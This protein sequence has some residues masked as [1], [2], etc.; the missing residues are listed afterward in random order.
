MARS[1]NNKIKLITLLS[2]LV[3]C[4]V[5]GMEA[6]R[7]NLAMEWQKYQNKYKTT[8]LRIASS[9]AEKRLARAYPIKMRQIFLPG[10][11]RTDR[12]V[13][14][15]VG[16][17]DPRM[18][19]MEQPLRSHPGK[20]L[21]N[22]D[23]EKFGCTIC[24]DGQGQAVTTDE[25]HA[26]GSRFFW[27]KPLLPAEFTRS[28]CLRCHDADEQ[29]KTSWVLKGKALF[30]QNGCLGCHKLG[31]R[32][33]RIGL[34]LSRLGD[35]SFHLKRPVGK[36]EEVYLNRF[37][38]NKNIAYIFESIAD[39]KAQPSSSLM[40]DFKFRDDAVLALTAFLK[41]MTE[42]NVP[43]AFLPASFF[44]RLYQDETLTGEQV[45]TMYCSACHG[46]KA[47]GKVK[48]PNTHEG[49]VP[50]LFKVKEAYT[51]KELYMAMK[52][53]KIAEKV[54]PDGPTPLN[55]PAWN[56]VLSDK[57]IERVTDYLFSLMP[58]GS[59]DW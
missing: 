23:V 43:N 3:V 9:D 45:F 36:N 58:K 49:E 59:D 18:S 26:Q 17:E 55:M 44:K 40:L 46:Q 24:H 37:G 47:I 50:A 14:C 53:G 35:A 2:G 5:L 1:L 48:N 33:P 16:T 34:D 39:P 8:L 30:F 32:G 11:N 12:C 21:E 4:V 54:K 31:R 52:D 10:L 29:E 41:G 19:E 56:D 20:F 51:R 15:H 38:H 7:E 57:E 22:H 13:I 27:E 25:A 42:P 6:W 28:N